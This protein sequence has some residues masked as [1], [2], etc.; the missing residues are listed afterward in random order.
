L[1]QTKLSS[2]PKRTVVVKIPGLR[3]AASFRAKS[4]MTLNWR[5][6]RVR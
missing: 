5:L 2:R 6:Q 3:I 4:S 1:K